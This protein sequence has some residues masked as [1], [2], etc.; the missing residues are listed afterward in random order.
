MN[1]NPEE[2]WDTDQEQY[3]V[4]FTQIIFHWTV[5]EVDALMLRAEIGAGKDLAVYSEMLANGYLA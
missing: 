5:S 2:A 3:D 4:A 1:P